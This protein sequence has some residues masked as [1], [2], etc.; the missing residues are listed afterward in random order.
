M[1][2]AR[3][4]EEPGCVDTAGATVYTTQAPDHP[5][6]RRKRAVDGV[7]SRRLPSSCRPE[8][9]PCRAAPAW[10]FQFHQRWSAV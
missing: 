2:E 5:P 7:I 4:P 10:Q 8:P 1:Q 6:K 3:G 9:Y